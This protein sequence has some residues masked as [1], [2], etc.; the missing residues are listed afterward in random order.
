MPVEDKDKMELLQLTNRS[1]SVID[2]KYSGILFHY[3][4]KNNF[5]EADENEL[6]QHYSEYDES[7]QAS[8]YSLAE[9]RIYDII[10][11]ESIQLDD[12]L[13]SRLLIHS[14]CD[15]S[16]KIQLWARAIPVLNEEMC[17]KHFEELGFS[18]LKGIFTKRNNLNR[19]YE[20][21]DSVEAIFE[22]LKKHTWI[23]DYREKEDAPGRYIVIKNKPGKS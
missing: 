17:K 9:R 12:N 1:V 6:Y 3:I 23:Y 22:A 5:D 7:K 4:L 21:K 15:I 11:S 19:T 2:K 14:S 18:E 13:L 10:D 16:T 20:I 8:I